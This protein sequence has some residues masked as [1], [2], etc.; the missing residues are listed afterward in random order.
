MTL[1]QPYLTRLKAV[2]LLLLLFGGALALRPFLTS[3]GPLLAQLSSELGI[4]VQALG[5]LTSMPMLLMG[6]G[7]TDCPLAT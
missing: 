1:Q 4:E 6:G 2:A 7:S 5:W 3:P